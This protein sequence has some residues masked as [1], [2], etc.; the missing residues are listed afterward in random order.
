M[1]LQLRKNNSS[2]HLLDHLKELNDKFGIRWTTEK[3]PTRSDVKIDNCKLLMSK[4]RKGK[5][6]TN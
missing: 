2:Q 3:C 4:F 6:L 5:L 1:T